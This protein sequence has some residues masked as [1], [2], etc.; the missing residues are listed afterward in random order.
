M[1][2]RKMTKVICYNCGT[3]F[4]KPDSEAKRN[5]EVGRRNFCSRSCVGKTMIGN[6]SGDKRYTIP[7]T[8]TKD[9]YSAFREFIRR[10]KNRHHDYD[11]DIEYL[12]EL[13]NAQ[14]G[15]CVY[16]GIPMVLP[17]GKP[18]NMLTASLDRINSSLGYV[19]GNVQ[20]ILTPINYMKNTMTHEQTI[21]LINLIKT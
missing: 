3:E 13:W 2:K 16:T 7:P 17:N 8:R 10:V 14:E 19:K 21:E 20:F 15:K 9:Q 11:I 12:Y 6:V 18:G 1:R 5:A 4:E